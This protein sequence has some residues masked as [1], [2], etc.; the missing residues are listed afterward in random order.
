M[1]CDT[2]VVFSPREWGCAIPRKSKRGRST[3][4]DADNVLP[5]MR[6]SHATGCF[7]QR[8]LG[9]HARPRCSEDR[10]RRAD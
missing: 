1:D 10:S 4:L 8:V 3:A 2:C 9:L 7:E 5:E 6:R